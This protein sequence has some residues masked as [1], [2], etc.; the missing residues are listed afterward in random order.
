VTRARA[1]LQQ[2]A[3]A[4]TQEAI[5]KCAEG[6][7]LTRRAARLE[8]LARMSDDPQCER[9]LAACVKGGLIVIDPATSAAKINSNGGEG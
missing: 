3:E 6:M 2:A 8:Q 7:A 9:L 4:L 5:D 1:L